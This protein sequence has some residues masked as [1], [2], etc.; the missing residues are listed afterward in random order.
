MI[1]KQ[2]MKKKNSN[3][4]NSIPCGGQLWVRHTED[5]AAHKNHYMDHTKILDNLRNKTL[6]G[7]KN[8]S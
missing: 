3:D 8:I 5:G 2:N 4:L 6:H 1:S 7:Y